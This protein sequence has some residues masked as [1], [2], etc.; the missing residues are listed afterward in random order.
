MLRLIRAMFPHSL[1]DLCFHGV[2]VE[3]RTP[4]HRWILDGR[5]SQLRH[6]LLDEHEAPELV[7][8][9]VKIFVGSDIAIATTGPCSV[10]EGIRAQVHQNRYVGMVL[11]TDPAAG[12][13]NEAILEIVDPNRGEVAFRE[14]E[15]LVT[16]RR[17]FAGDQVHLVVAVEMV[18]VGLVAHL[19]ALQ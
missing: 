18:L 8:E 15:D 1:R 17:P 11:G 4:L 10:F 16:S 9:P 12:L 19:L 6:F 5:L 2:E 3:A 7:E 13:A 14:V